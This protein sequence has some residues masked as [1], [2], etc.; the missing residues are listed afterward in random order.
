MAEGARGMDSSNDLVDRR[1]GRG[2][3]KV[4]CSDVVSFRW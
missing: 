3:D 4:I 1:Q 2:Q